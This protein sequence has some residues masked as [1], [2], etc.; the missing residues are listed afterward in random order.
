MFLTIERE[1]YKAGD[2]IF[3]EGSHGTAVYLLGAGKVEISKTVQDRKIVVEI[4][5]PGDIFGEMSYIDHSPR[6]ATAIALEDTVLELIDKNF[7]DKEFN[8][9]DS[10]FREIIT[11]LVRRLRKT[12]QRLVSLPRRIGKRVSG[13]INISFKKADDFFKSY[14]ANFGQG[15]LFI[16]TTKNLPVGSLLDLEFNLP[17]SNQEITTK[18]KVMWIRPQDMSTEK[19]PPGMGIQFINMNPNDSK[20]LKNYLAKFRSS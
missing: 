12:T 6:S 18:G 16:H 8:Q 3:K 7:L 9:I 1:T 19:M 15:G 17:D 13:K 10:D 4:L 5:G 11:T 20:L 2:V 14:I